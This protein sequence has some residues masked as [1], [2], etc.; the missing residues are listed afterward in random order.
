MSGIDG[1][2][3]DAVRDRCALDVDAFVFLLFLFSCTFILIEMKWELKK[4]DVS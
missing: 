3:A 1:Y 2:V 4:R